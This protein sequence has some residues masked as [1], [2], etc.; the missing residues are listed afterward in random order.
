MPT[1]GALYFVG[2][3]GAGMS[4]IAHVLAERGRTVFGADPGI[5]AP[6]QAR[7][8]AVGATVYTTHDAAN[9]GADVSAV[10][11]SDAIPK[12]NPEVVAA[13]E[14]GI[15]VYRRP[16]VLGEIV[17]AGRGIAI[18][19]THGKTTTTGMVASI[20]IHAGLDPTVLI[21]GDLPLIGGNARNGKGEFVVAES[22]EA[23]DG[24]LY[25]H[26]EVALILNIEA[27]HLDYHGDEAHVIGSFERFVSQV[28]EY[29]TAIVCSDDA[30]AK[31][32]G[33]KA[34][35]HVDTAV[36]SVAPDFE[37]V[38]LDNI[39]YADNI[40]MQDETPSFTLK[41]RVRKYTGDADTDSI[42]IGRVKLGVPGLHNVSNSVAAAFVGV[43]AGVAREHIVAGLES[44]T[45]TGRRFERIG[46][47]GGVTIIDD[48][49]HHP[50]ELRATLSAAR[51][52][53]PG[54]RIVAVFQPHL[55]SRTR[56]LMDEFADALAYGCSGWVVA[57]AAPGGRAP[58]P[59]APLPRCA[60]EGGGNA[61]NDSSVDSPVLID[62][63]TA[64]TPPSPA[65]RGRGAGGVGARPPGA[66]APYAVYLTDIYLAREAT[67]PGVSSATL[68]ERIA[69]LPDAPPVVYVP[70]KDD[71][72]ARLAADVRPGDV[73]IT[74][75]AGDIRPA[76]EGLLALLSRM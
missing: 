39:L 69:A 7:L 49:A 46:E 53:F 73:V 63:G 10:I 8:E 59:P 35:S 40:E 54:R 50:T 34:V 71:L 29:G 72:P 60:G 15:P 64:S 37:S 17:N 26:P 42:L 2:I 65:Q 38:P 57:A 74:L 48:Y 70:D 75:G 67:I 47:A 11:V 9:V 14:R 1:T 20:L 68:A 16:E 5:A 12:A 52:A 43:V 41:H 13:T 62:G 21:G 56:D 6:L 58:T 27:D 19:G 24:F 36:Y 25:L 4:A 76:G 55:P 66:A 44:F 3:G 18:A 31:A 32:V 33:I 23:Y 28:N 22:C 51:S 61:G 30:K 45:G